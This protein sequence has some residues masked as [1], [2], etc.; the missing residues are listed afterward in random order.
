MKV[1]GNFFPLQ[2]EVLTSQQLQELARS[3]MKD[4][5]LKTFE[6]TWELNSAVSVEGIGRFRINIFRSRG[7]P[8]MVLRYIKGK[9]PSLADLALPPILKTIISELRGLVLV[10]GGTGS[11]KSTSLASMIDYRNETQSGHI[12]LIED[13]IE[14]IHQ[15]KKSIV[16]QREIGIDTMNFENAL[17]NAMR[18]APDVIVIGEIRDRAAMKY[19]IAYAETGHLCLATLHANN[20]NQAMDR[21][22]N[23]FP[24][25]AKQQLLLDLSLN[26]KS[27]ISLRL[28]PSL[29]SKLVPAVEILLNSPY[30]ADRIE[31]GKIED[32][33]D[34][35]AKSK[36]QGMQTFD[37]ALLQLY[38][39]GQISAD[40]AIRFA[41]SKNNVGLEIRLNHSME[42]KTDQ[43]LKI[44][45]DPEKDL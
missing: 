37:Q 23:F 19:A 1:E 11:G 16:N 34:V 10:V 12:L 28:V 5:D 4:Q 8:A 41:D 42:N 36:E 21:I 18:E 33:K 44:T 30:I 43:N 38:H 22:I 39:S 29:Q 7:E 2:T 26:L 25:E 3:V 45:P 35:M 32:I 17:F 13:P 31:K 6:E 9:I 20:A 40:D 14:F 24:E 15:H 27:I